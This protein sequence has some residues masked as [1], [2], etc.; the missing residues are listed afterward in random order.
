MA[1]EAEGRER[2]GCFSRLDGA[3]VEEN[4]HVRGVVKVLRHRVQVPDAACL[5]IGPT[6][7]GKRVARDTF[8]V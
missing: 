2:S 4:S 5:L 7:R 8:V 1:T 6:D 3:P